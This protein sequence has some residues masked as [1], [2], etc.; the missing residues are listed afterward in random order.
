MNLDKVFLFIKLS[1]II[2]AA[3]FYRQYSILLCFVVV[4]EEK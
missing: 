1:F 2:K 4:F 3:I